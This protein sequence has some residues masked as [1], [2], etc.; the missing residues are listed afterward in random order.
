MLQAGAGGPPSGRVG[1]GGPPQGLGAE[2]GGTPSS[3]DQQPVGLFSSHAA[4]DAKTRFFIIRSS[5][6][7]NVEVSMQRG[8]WATIP[9][10]EARLTEAVQEAQRV[11]LF[12]RVQSSSSWSGYA[13]MK[14][15]PGQGS[16]PS[17]VF[18]GRSGRPFVGRTFDVEWIRKVPL[19]IEKTRNLFNRF[20]N[21]ES[22]NRAMDGQP[23]DPEA[24]KALVLMFD[25]AAGSAVG[26][27]SYFGP[28]YGAP[29]GAHPPA[30]YSQGFPSQLQQ[31]PG[32]RQRAVQQQ[33]QQRQRQQDAAVLQQQQ[34]QLQGLGTSQRKKAGGR[35]QQTS[36]GS[37]GAGCSAD[38]AQTKAPQNPA[39]RIF[40][41]DLTEM[42]YDDY[43]ETYEASQALWQRVFA[44]HGYVVGEE[45]V[46]GEGQQQGEPIEETR[47]AE[48]TSELEEASFMTAEGPREDSAA[49]EGTTGS[50]RAADQSTSTATLLGADGEPQSQVD[51]DSHGSNGDA[52][53]EHKPKNLGDAPFAE[54]ETEFAQVRVKGELLS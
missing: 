53:T 11:V 20:N 48:V 52:A 49:S 9:R 5:T 43:I 18:A 35:R 37:P 22:V 16:C 51:A 33:Q 25:E 27:L 54:A 29:L 21:G 39:M 44:K 30:G 41:I 7:Y 40:P 12:F 1:G 4:E 15:A 23:V 14:N 47:K 36:E 38:E 42:T 45:L 46:N 17:C 19:S 31:H 8:V 24:G 28:A 34:Q 13:F 10:N 6:E 3:F 50:S 32:V 26:G 2:D